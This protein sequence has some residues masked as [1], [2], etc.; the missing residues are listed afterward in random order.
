VFRT[1]AAAYCQRF[2]E[3]LGQVKA[4]SVPRAAA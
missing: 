4:Q 2:T 1:T 3:A